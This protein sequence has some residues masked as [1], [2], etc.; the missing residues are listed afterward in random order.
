M[1]TFWQE[2]LI[3]IST[4]VKFLNLSINAFQEVCFFD[5]KQFCFVEEKS[6]PRLN[7][8]SYIDLW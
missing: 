8:Y 3:I 6:T 4:F 2:G 5:M 7:S 1:W